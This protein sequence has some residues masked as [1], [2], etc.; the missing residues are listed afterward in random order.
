MEPQVPGILPDYT[1]FCSCHLWF[2]NVLNQISVWNTKFSDAPAGCKNFTF[3]CDKTI[4]PFRCYL[5]PCLALKK[6]GALTGTEL[7]LAVVTCRPKMTVGAEAPA[8]Y[9][10]TGY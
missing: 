8:N 3:Q 5:K 10:L 6:C 2:T 4:I 9:L 7:P 1:T